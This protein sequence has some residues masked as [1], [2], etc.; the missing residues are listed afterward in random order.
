MNRYQNITNSV[1]STATLFLFKMIIII[2][3]IKRLSQ[4][5]KYH[6]SKVTKCKVQSSKV[7]KFV[8]LN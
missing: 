5:L 6:K 1:F 7:R 2:I 8:K 3:I 4:A